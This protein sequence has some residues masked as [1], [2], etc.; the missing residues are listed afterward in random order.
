MRGAGSDRRT[1][2]SKEKGELMTC[3]SLFV[4]S[5][6]V[7]KQNANKKYGKVCTVLCYNKLSYTWFEYCHDFCVRTEWLN[8]GSEKDIC[9]VLYCSAWR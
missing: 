7:V 3:F 1:S 9:A 2:D 5:P 8:F 4:T 6:T